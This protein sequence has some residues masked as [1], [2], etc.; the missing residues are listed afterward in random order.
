MAVDRFVGWQ[1]GAHQSVLA[2]GWKRLSPVAGREVAGSA[3]C[4]VKGNCNPVFQ[5]TILCLT[6]SASIERSSPLSDMHINKERG[7]TT[8]VGQ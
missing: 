5:R 8:G 2:V 7:A 6:G 1:A 4:R 3:F